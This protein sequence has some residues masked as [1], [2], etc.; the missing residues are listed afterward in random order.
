MGQLL[1]VDRYESIT[2]GH[3]LSRLLWISR[4]GLVVVG[5]TLYVGWAVVV[6]RL[7]CQSL[8][9]SRCGLVDVS[10]SLLVGSFEG[11]SLLGV[12]LSTLLH[13][14]PCLYLD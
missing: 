13:F 6:G 7:L 12:S 8:W 11:L 3:L 4:C 14:N 5:S 9:I 10:W 2:V 1:W